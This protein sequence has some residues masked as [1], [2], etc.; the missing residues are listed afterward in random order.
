MLI[1]EKSSKACAS[2]KRQDKT[3]KSSLNTEKEKG[4]PL[5]HEQTRVATSTECKI[6]FFFPQKA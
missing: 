2:Q 1:T 4:G 3:R 6:D 5:A